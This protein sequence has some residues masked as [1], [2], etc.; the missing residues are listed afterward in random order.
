MERSKLSSLEVANL[1]IDE[2]L[3]VRGGD[4]ATT[5]APPVKP[6]IDKDIIL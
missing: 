2:M 6:G 3:N 1:A 5:P 4:S